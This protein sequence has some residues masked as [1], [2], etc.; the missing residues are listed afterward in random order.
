MKRAL[1]VAISL[2]AMYLALGSVALA[3]N[4]HADFTTN[5]DACASC[6][7]V[8]TATS[9]NLLRDPTG[10]AMCETCHQAGAGAD[11]DVMNGKYIDNADTAPNHIAWGDANMNLLGGGF[12]AIQNTS[13]TTSSHKMGTSITPFAPY[14]SDPNNGPGAVITLKCLSCHSA[15]PDKLHPNQYRLLRIRP[16]GSSVDKLVPWNG[17]WDSAAQTTKSSDPTAYRAYTDKD[18]DPERPDTQVY[19]MNYKSGQDAWCASCHTRY[20]TRQDTTPY[21]AGDV[22]GS[23]M[24]FRHNT[25]SMITGVVDPINGLHYDLTTDLPLNHPT[26]EP[27]EDTMSCLTC[28]RSHGTDAVMSAQAAMGDIDVDHPSDRHVPGKEGL[29]T[30]STLLRRAQRGVCTNCHTNI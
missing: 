23:V 24:R 30:G 13:T 11:T 26:G 1:A 22:F 20:T 17:P 15:H 7:R 3:G 10:T 2:I 8:H 16:N 27:T 12:K 21:D 9:G 6:H 25:D 18:F 28:H 14:G 29:P 19:T 5:P 4:P